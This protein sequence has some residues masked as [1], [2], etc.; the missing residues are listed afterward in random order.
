MGTLISNA[1]EMIL[2]IDHYNDK[3]FM[4]NYLIEFCYKFNRRYFGEKL[5]D[6]LMIAA[7]DSPWCAFR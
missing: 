7:V 4:Q 3:M 1:K 5:F 6:R 2:G